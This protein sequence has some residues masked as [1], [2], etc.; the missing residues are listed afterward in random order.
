MFHNLPRKKGVSGL[1]VNQRTQED[2]W[3]IMTRKVVVNE[4]VDPGRG[5]DDV[6]VFEG[7]SNP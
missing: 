7:V 6:K 4:I 3:G 1:I 2:A 5:P